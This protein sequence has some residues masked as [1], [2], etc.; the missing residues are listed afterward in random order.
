MKIKICGGATYITLLAIVTSSVNCEL[1]SETV[2]R[3]HES[4]LLKPPGILKARCN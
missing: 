3:F 1:I 4:S 2:D